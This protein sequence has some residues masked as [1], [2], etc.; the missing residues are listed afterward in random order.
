MR[1][2]SKGGDG[3]PSTVESSAE[4]QNRPASEGCQQDPPQEANVPCPILPVGPHV[5]PQAQIRD[6]DTERVSSLPVAT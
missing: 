3:A 2:C 1:L 4:P 5:H 6:Q